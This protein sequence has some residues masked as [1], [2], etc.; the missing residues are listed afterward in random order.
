[1]DPRLTIALILLGVIAAVFA[2]A[3]CRLAGSADDASDKA[4]DQIAHGDVAQLPRGLSKRGDLALTDALGRS[5]PAL[6]S[7][8]HDGADS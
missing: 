8:P 4:L 5:E 7:P 3:A 6:K 1:M 2:Y